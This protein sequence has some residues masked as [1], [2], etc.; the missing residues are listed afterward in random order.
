M[1]R[2]KAEMHRASLWVKY[3][4]ISWFFYLKAS[5]IKP[6]FYIKTLRIFSDINVIKKMNE[7]F[8]GIVNIFILQTNC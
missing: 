3:K 6:Y 8:A 7:Q 2:I 4:T 5:F 1:S